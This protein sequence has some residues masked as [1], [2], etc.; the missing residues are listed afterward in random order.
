LAKWPADK[1]LFDQL[2]HHIANPFELQDKTG[3][4]SGNMIEADVNPIV[5]VYEGGNPLIDD[6]PLKKAPLNP[7][8]QSKSFIQEIP[9]PGSADLSSADPQPAVP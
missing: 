6:R 3:Y 9:I 4:G 1:T 5:P 8:L 7:I 2:Y